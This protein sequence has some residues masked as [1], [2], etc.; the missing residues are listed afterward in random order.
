MAGVNYWRKTVALL[1]LVFFANTGF[2]ALCDFECS[3]FE[4]RPTNATGL[5]DARA[6]T[7]AHHGHH[8][9]TS[10]SGSSAAVVS[11]TTPSSLCEHPEQLTSEF[12]LASKK[13]AANALPSIQSAVAP[14]LG[15][16][17]N[18]RVGTAESPPFLSNVPLQISL[19]I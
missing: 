1:T 15:N 7:P 14:M 4:A 12:K 2:A 13:A 17:D 16:P 8:L 3:I 9:Q 6:S 11:V 18:D 10:S 19:R 5:F